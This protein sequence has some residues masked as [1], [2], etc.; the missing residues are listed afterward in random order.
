MHTIDIL[1]LASGR[2]LFQ[3]GM[4]KLKL[5]PGNPGGLGARLGKTKPKTT[6]PKDE[7]LEALQ[8]QNGIGNIGNTPIPEKLSALLKLAGLTRFV[9]KAKTLFPVSKEVDT[10][11]KLL[12]AK[13]KNL[14]RLQLQG[15]RNQLQTDKNSF[16]N[17]KSLGKN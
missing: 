3:A 6:M 17:L 8:L 2:K 15:M 10:D 13:H 4:T 12:S 16:T 14:G 5:K 9:P 1:K 7:Q 11:L